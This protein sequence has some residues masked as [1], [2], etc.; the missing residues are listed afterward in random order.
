MNV[1]NAIPTDTC[2]GC[3]SCMMKCPKQC[4]TMEERDNGFLY[5]IVDDATCVDCGLCVKACPTRFELTKFEPQHVYTARLRDK[6]ILNRVNSGGAF[7]AIAMNVL[8]QGGIV[9]GASWN[10]SL[11]VVHECITSIEALPKLQGSKYVQSRSYDCFN[12]I[13]TALNTGT[14]VVYSG[15]GCQ[16]AGLKSFL[17]K[18]YDNL[19]TV[20]V[21]CHG[22]P[23]P[24]LFRRY[25]EW[26]GTKAGGKITS[27]RFRSKHKRPTGEHSEYF[28]KCNGTEYTGRSYEDPYYGSFLQGRTLRPSCYN[29]QFKGKDRV[30][31]ITLGDFWGIEKSHPEFPTKNGH[32][33]VLVNTDKGAKVMS[34]ISYSLEYVE[35]NWGE[36]VMRNHSLLATAECKGLELDLNSPTLFD[37]DLKVKLSFKSKVKNRLPWRVKLLLKKYL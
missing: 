12:E 18:E 20:E 3:G 25:L 14:V 16:V 11:E 17:Q 26:L 8:K 1:I 13:K 37:K 27:F 23:S 10:D 9:C 4:I 6:T 15:T 36:A 19:I 35:S 21:V 22:V 28:Y 5:P 7:S 31:D 30:A 24:G 32:S 2:V 34:E 33:L 29:C